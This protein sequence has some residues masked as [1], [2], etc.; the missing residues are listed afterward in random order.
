MIDVK[1]ALE[2]SANNIDNFDYLHNVNQGLVVKREIM[3]LKSTFQYFYANYLITKRD[4]LN[5]DPGVIYLEKYTLDTSLSSEVSELITS[6]LVKTSTFLEISKKLKTIIDPNRKKH[7][8]EVVKNYFFEGL[9]P[10]VYMYIKNIQTT[11]FINKKRDNTSK[12][13]TYR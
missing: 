9:L 4:T 2:E 10:I 11:F 6:E 13:D 12:M 8:Q 1:D 7:E 3:K 5:K